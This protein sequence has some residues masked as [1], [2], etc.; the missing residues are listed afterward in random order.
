MRISDWSSDV[1]SSDLRPVAGQQDQPLGQPQRAIGM[2]GDKAGGKRIGKGPVNRDGIEGGFGVRYEDRDSSPSVR[3]E[4]VEG[5]FCLL[6]KGKEKDSASTRSAR[7]VESDISGFRQTSV[8]AASVGA[9]R[10]GLPTSN[11]CPICAMP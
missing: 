3:P 1:C 10:P 7:T 11:H 8:N 5:P 6:T 2:A 9:M 4:R